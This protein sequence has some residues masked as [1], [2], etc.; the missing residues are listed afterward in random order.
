MLIRYYKSKKVT[1]CIKLWIKWRKVIFIFICVDWIRKMED[2]FMK[3][4][5]KELLM[6]FYKY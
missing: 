1:N 3:M 5:S 6:K 4:L 2:I